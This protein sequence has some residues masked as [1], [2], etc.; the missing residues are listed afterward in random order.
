MGEV[1]AFLW[2]R[3]EV[4]DLLDELGL[5]GEVVHPAGAAPSTLSAIASP[6]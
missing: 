2:R 4:R 3:P 5:A 1:F 6:E